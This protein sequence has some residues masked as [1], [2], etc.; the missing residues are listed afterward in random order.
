[1]ASGFV[2]SL[3]NPGGHITGFV[4]LEGSLGGKWI[5]LLKDADPQLK[6]AGI[7]F[8]P[9][10][11]PYWEYYQRPFDQAA[12]AFGIQSESFRVASTAQI[13]SA[14]TALA[15]PPAGALS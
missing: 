1:L 11:A 2:S 15:A 3:P 5:A 13:E 6:R 8:N 10:T 14:V 4:N 7:L 12:R 9:D